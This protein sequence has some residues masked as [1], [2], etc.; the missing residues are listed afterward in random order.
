MTP[1]RTDGFDTQI[2]NPFG[3]MNPEKT[4]KLADRYGTGNVFALVLLAFVLGVF[5]WFVRDMHAMLNEHIRATTAGNRTSFQSCISLA[6]LAG[7][8]REG[9][10]PPDS[11]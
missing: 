5:T 3:G 4:L 9:C 10:L 2:I 8:P 11:K 6:V 1:R 7:T